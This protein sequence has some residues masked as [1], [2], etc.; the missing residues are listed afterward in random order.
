[1]SMLPSLRPVRAMALALLFGTAGVAHATETR[2]TDNE[3]MVPPPTAAEIVPTYRASGSFDSAIAHIRSGRWTD[4]RAEIVAMQ[5]RS[6]ANF[7]LAELY[8]AAG[9]PRVEGDALRTLLSQSP[10]LPQAQQLANLARS[11]GVTDV[12]I[13][14]ANRLAWAGSTPRRGNPRPISDA[15]LDPL[16]SQ[17]QAQIS[18]D[19]PAGAEAMLMSA[20]GASMEALTEWRAR[21]AWSY[22]IENDD[23]NA[24]RMA[25]LAQTG[26]GE[27]AVQASWA[28]GLAAWRQRDYDAAATAFRTVSGRASDPELMAQGSY[29]LARASVAAGRPQDAQ[30]A[31]RRAAANEETFYGQLAAEA[32]ALP[33]APVSLGSD[34]AADARVAALPNVRAARAMA[35]AGQQQLAD[36]TLRHQARI[37]APSDHAALIRVAA[38]LGLAETQY[39]LAHNAP[40]GMRQPLAARFPSLN[41]APAEG[42]RIS[43]ALAMAH[44][45]QESSFR[46]GV[47]SPAGAVGLMQVKPIAAS[48]MGRA[49]GRDALTDPA[50]NLSY[51]QGY[52]EQLRDSSFTGGL[53]PKVIAAYNAGPTPVTRWNAEVRDGGDPLLWIESLPYWET[54]AYVGI[55]LR[56]LWVYESAMGVPGTSRTEL[57]SGRWARVPTA[58]T[59]LA[60]RRSTTIASGSD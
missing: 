2:S 50:T 60:G 51:G 8:L 32:L 31:M 47:V 45:L 15:I 39:F 20:G 16:K 46:S 34:A 43:P 10:D 21:I 59:R 38:Q 3:V 23:F 25:A 18:A 55:V 1:M 28:E 40:S 30:T 57:A 56:N 42:W 48:H 11:R 52:I 53:L 4:A 37:G 14:S 35:A 17:M 12:S 5:D 33:R 7:A 41:I 44:T 36:E 22:Y 27:W 29:W 13:A 6:L 24:R 19:N 54:R 9:S 26:M 49:S 58:P